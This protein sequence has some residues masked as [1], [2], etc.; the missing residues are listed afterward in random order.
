ML[1]LSYCSQVALC[2][3]DKMLTC[4]LIIAFYV[5][6]KLPRI[7][8]LTVEYSYIYIYY[9]ILTMISCTFMGVWIAM[10]CI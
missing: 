1:H 4:E 7:L 3:L 2:Y 8:D 9:D 10:Y 6:H 5:Y